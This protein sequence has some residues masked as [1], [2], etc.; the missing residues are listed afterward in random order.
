[1]NMKEIKVTIN[2]KTQLYNQFNNSQLS[3][4]LSQYLYNQCRGLSVKTDFKIIINHNFF[5]N[6]EEKKKLVDEIRE[7]YG[8]DIK[9]NLISLKMERI[10]EFFYMLI[11]VV[12]LFISIL[13]A[14]KSSSLVSEIFLIFGW[15]LL[16]EIGHSI[17]FFSNIIIKNKR[18]KKLINA[19][20][21]FC[22]YDEKK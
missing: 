4:E 1:M 17:T 2:E 14:N 18:Y 22:E 3:D 9:E 8:I 21:I 19:K 16:W 10:K 12:L 5:M 13:F 6:D 7:N 11:G 15:Y 20:I